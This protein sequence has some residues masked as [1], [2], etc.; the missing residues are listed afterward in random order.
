MTSN[1]K[2]TIRNK[3]YIRH[4]QNSGRN[5]TVAG[6]PINLSN[7][8]PTWLHSTVTR[9]PHISGSSTVLPFWCPW[10]WGGPH[11]CWTCSQVPGTWFSPWPWPWPCGQPPSYPKLLHSKQEP[12]PLLQPGP[13]RGVNLPVNFPHDVIC[14][15][16]H[17]WIARH[18]HCLQLRKQHVH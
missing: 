8:F 9:K 10:G 14:T 5:G 7:L 1:R 11:A 16:K 12:C 18:P 17:K 4:S 2:E 3:G 15:M 13:C 6:V